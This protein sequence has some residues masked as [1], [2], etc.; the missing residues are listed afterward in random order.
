MNIDLQKTS[1]KKRSNIN[2]S[3]G[4]LLD[5]LVHLCGQT[6]PGI[7]INPPPC[8]TT[9]EKINQLYSTYITVIE[10]LRYANV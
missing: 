1:L 10:F 8:N 4:P 6:P 7:P 2:Q 3:R 5:L 9:L